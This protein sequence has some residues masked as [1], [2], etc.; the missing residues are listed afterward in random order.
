MPRDLKGRSDHDKPAA[1]HA[2]ARTL[3]IFLRLIPSRL[4]GRTRAAN[5]LIGLLGDGPALVTGRY[6]IR[7]RLP[8]LA[9]P[10]A[11]GIVADGLYEGATHAAICRHLPASGVFLDIGANIGAIA[12]PVARAKPDASVYAIEASP[13]IYATLEFN[14]S[15]N[16]Q[17]NLQLRRYFVGRHDNATTDFFEAPANKFG[18]GSAGPQFGVDPKTLPVVSIDALITRGEI[19]RP[20]VIKL[21]IEGSELAA[22]QGC[23]EL[24][25]RSDRP[26]AVIFEFNDWAED[27]LGL[28]PGASQELMM[29][30]GYRLFRLSDPSR[31]LAEPIGTGGAMILA[32]S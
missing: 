24:L 17:R 22:L 23:E 27:R 28:E 14:R 30:Y 2:L 18:M 9:E 13:S 6:G 8:S 21:D 7:Y 4:P 15:L 5:L 26:V 31:E 20:D 19:A 10:I 16:C 3:G 25:T 32:L 1:K 12:L 29:T 11:R